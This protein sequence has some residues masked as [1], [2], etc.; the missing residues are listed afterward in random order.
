MRGEDAS[1][2]WN[3]SSW[4]F[5]AHAIRS[6]EN[7]LLKARMQEA[8]DTDQP[9]GD[10]V[11]LEASALQRLEAFANTFMTFLESLEDGVVTA[12]LWSQ[13]ESGLLDR[14]KSK[15]PLR[16][17]EE[18]MQ[19]LEILSSSPPHNISFTLITFMLSRVA[20]ELTPADSTAEVPTIGNAPQSPK[21]RNGQNQLN[22]RRS[23]VVASYAA[24]FAHV[25][26]RSPEGLKDKE[27]KASE[28][29][30]K[31]VIELFVRPSSEGS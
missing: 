30:K 14:E 12:N 29:R 19:I 17:E 27:R 18:R 7:E 2:P 13:V 20:N 15:Q 26:I 24:I 28:V 16:P 1:P 9:F 11:P 23:E 3:D 5:T 6:N 4:P 21:E 8:L 31:H 22:T 10:L 25:I